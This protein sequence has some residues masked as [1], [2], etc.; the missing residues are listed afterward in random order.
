[1]NS[2]N[3]N[4]T[5]LGQLSYLWRV[6]SATFPAARHHRLVPNYTAWWQRHM[7]ANN[8]PR[9]ARD[10]GRSA[11][12]EH[13]TCWSQ[14]QHSK[15]LVTKPHH[16]N[17]EKWCFDAVGY[18]SARPL[19]PKKVSHQQFPPIRLVRLVDQQGT[20][21]NPWYCDK[22]GQSYKSQECVHILHQ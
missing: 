13:A 3:K 9:G 20:R 12:F 19:G 10:S 6:A 14:V 22:T 8:V 15:H 5:E 7:C 1:M 17:M 21:L 16:V 11:V 2:G 18:I 4:C